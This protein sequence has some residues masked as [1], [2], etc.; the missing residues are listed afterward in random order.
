MSTSDIFAELVYVNSPSPVGNGSSGGVKSEW[1]RSYFLLQKWR[2][3]RLFKAIMDSVSVSLKSFCFHSIHPHGQEHL[4]RG[5]IRHFSVHWLPLLRLIHAKSC[6]YI[7]RIVMTFKTV[8][9]HFVQHNGSESLSHLCSKPI[10]FWNLCVRL[11]IM[12]WWNRWRTR[13][14]NCSPLQNIISVS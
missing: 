5:L 9:Y 12:L 11:V 13:H 2:K 6:G 8:G 4:Q 1:R 14:S 3:K 7:P 10:P